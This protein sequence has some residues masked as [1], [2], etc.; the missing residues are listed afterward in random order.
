MVEQWAFNPLVAGSSPAGGTMKKL[1]YFINKIFKSKS[2]DLSLLDYPTVGGYVFWHNR[3][4]EVVLIGP[5]AT[6]DSAWDWYKNHGERLGV[7]YALT[8][9]RYPATTYNGIWGLMPEEQ[10]L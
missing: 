9:M 3:G 7:H 1:Y 2:K 8:H 10:N 5:F 4:N 6:L